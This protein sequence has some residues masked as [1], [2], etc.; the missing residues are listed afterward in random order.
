MAH[1]VTQRHGRR[2]GGVVDAA[3]FYFSRVAAAGGY[4]FFSSTAVDEQ[5]RFPAQAQVAPP[6]GMSA[7]AH[8]RAQTRYIFDQYKRD[9]LEVGSSIDDIV[10]IEQYLKQKAHADGY[11][12][13]A[14]GPGFMESNRP[15]SLMIQLGSSLPTGT[16]VNTTGMAIIPNPGKGLM[17]DYARSKKKPG[18]SHPGD[19]AD[20]QNANRAF[21]EIVTAGPYAFTTFFP[22]D[23]VSGIHP[24]ARVE[25]WIWWGSEI[26]GEAELAVRILAAR[27]E[28]VGSTF[29]DIINY[30]LYLTDLDD[31]YEFD[32]VWEQAVRSNPPSRTVVPAVGMG[33]PRREG[34]RGHAEGSPKM[35]AQFRILMPE[36]NGGR[37]LVVSGSPTL[38]HESE[39]VIADG[40]LWVSGQLAPD[41][42]NPSRPTS[43]PDQLARIMIR[44]DSVCRAA[45]TSM[46][47]LL[48]VRA[49]VTDVEDGYAVYAALKGAVASEPPSVCISG[50]PGPLQVPGCSV[51][52]DAVAYVPE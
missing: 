20:A 21:A 50:V 39:A 19:S 35:E 17:K 46:D 1:E 9:L 25:D 13:V 40:L 48:R 38:G 8:S 32:L 31:L 4:A 34:A 23:Y 6:Y 16:V 11:A 36:S 7:A 3:G 51:I 52:V 37:R 28:A 18:E 2:V 27:L 12:Q 44:L 41:A 45:G 42:D 10:Q 5:G 30:T 22:S 26:R 24:E 29:D 49:F 14:R 47:N 33:S 15:G 43:T